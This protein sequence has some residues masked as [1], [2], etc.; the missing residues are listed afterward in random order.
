MSWEDR[1]D[2]L[3][4]KTNS[5]V[6]PW[7]AHFMLGLMPNLQNF[8]DVQQADKTPLEKALKIFLGVQSVKLD[9]REQK[10]WQAMADERDI[11]DLVGNIRKAYRQ[12]SKSNFD[13]NMDDLRELI[14]NI[15]TSNAI[16]RSGEVRGQGLFRP[17]VVESAEQVQR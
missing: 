5:Y 8:I 15:K 17:N 4:G 13:S 12:D 16:K 1:R 3:T 14:V 10:I 9:L 2:K 6:N 11:N 7:M